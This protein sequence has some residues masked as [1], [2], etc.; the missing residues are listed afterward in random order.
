MNPSRRIRELYEQANLHIDPIVDQRILATAY[1]RL[2]HVTQSRPNTRRLKVWRF[3]KHSKYGRIAALAA[4]VLAVLLLVQHL[5]GGALETPQPVIVKTV[6]PTP[7]QDSPEKLL[8]NELVLAQ[9]Q[10]EQRDL[11]GLLTLLGTGMEPTQLKIAALLAEIGDASVIPVLQ[12]LADVWDGEGENPFQAAVNVIEIRQRPDRPEQID[13]NEE[14]GLNLN[15]T[16]PWVF[17]PEWAKS[18]EE[19]FGLDSWLGL[20]PVA[21]ASDHN[22]VEDLQLAGGYYVEA[23]VVDEQ[24]YPIEGVRVFASVQEAGLIGASPDFTVCDE[25]TD[26][27]GWAMMGAIKPSRQ[28]HQIIAHHTEYALEQVTLKLTGPQVVKQVNF[29]LK[30]GGGVHGYAEYSDGVPAEGVNVFLM[31]DWWRNGAMQIYNECLVDAQGLFTLESVVKG[32]YSVHVGIKNKNTDSSACIPISHVQFPLP[33]G[34]LLLVQIPRKSPASLASITGIVVWATEKRTTFGIFVEVCCSETGDFLYA[35]LDG[36]TES[37]EI[38]SLEPGNYTLK[39]TG[40]NIK[41]TVI[42]NVEAP[43]HGVELV[44]TYE[45]LRLRGQVVVAKTQEPMDQFEVRFANAKPLLGNGFMSGTNRWAECVNGQFD[46]WAPRPGAYQVQVMVPGYAVAYSPFIRTN[47]S[48]SV[49]IELV[50][51]G[52]VAGRVTNTAGEPVSDAIVMPLSYVGG[53][54]YR[55]G[56][57]FLSEQDMPKT[58]NGFFELEQ[59]PPG[60][61][62]IKVIHPDYLPQ[63]VENIEVFG[64]Q[65]TEQVEIVLN[66]GI[67]VEGYVFD[68]QGQPEANVALQCQKDPRFI[69]GPPIT[70]VTDATGYYRMNHLPPGEMYYIS[71]VNSETA[72]GTVRRAYRVPRWQMGRLDLGGHTWVSGVLEKDGEPLS[73]TKMRLSIPVNSQ[74]AELTVNGITDEV[75]R[76]V[77]FGVPD[78]RYGIFVQNSEKFNDYSRVAI[79]QIEE[80]HVDLGVI[81]V[82]SL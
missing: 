30:K 31:P 20:P 26:P 78:G 18:R 38:D 69:D 14:I 1:D 66:R 28:I 22:A 47:E 40:S 42:E 19:Y 57:S 49:T 44:L 5:T 16:N 65:T 39:I 46:I 58:V 2:D 81:S 45:E 41:E 63:L 8:A 61:E 4:A 25:I 32:N 70:A 11:P 27:N 21:L 51:G 48:E 80:N 9:S 24:G 35:S 64:G 50:Q 54:A 52:R 60:Y 6:E 10:Y 68:A 62:T 43:G 34:E 13:A 82:E 72:L 79:V 74:S 23:I 75:G 73:N 56:E 7:Q 33:E 3:I 53:D 36:Q 17:E 15:I 76:F 37:F 55:Y 59:L 71:R 77:L 67:S 29:V 12:G